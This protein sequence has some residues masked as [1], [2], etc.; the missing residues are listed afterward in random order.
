MACGLDDHFI[1]DSDDAMGN[2][3]RIG[4]VIVIVIAPRPNHILDREPERF[5]SSILPSGVRQGSVPWE[6]KRTRSN[7]KF[8]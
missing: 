3:A 7:P 5:S 8:L 4:A 1:A 2:F 6:K